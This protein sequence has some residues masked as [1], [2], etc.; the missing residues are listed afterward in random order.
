MFKIVINVF[1]TRHSFKNEGQL[2]PKP[3]F[4]YLLS[5]KWKENTKD[6]QKSE[7][8]REKKKDEKGKLTKLWKLLKYLALSWWYLSEGW[9]DITKKV[10]VTLSQKSGGGLLYLKRY[11]WDMRIEEWSNGRGSYIGR[12]DITFY[13]ALTPRS[14]V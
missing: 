5:S 12:V 14:T 4:Y 8:E 11:F 9:R 6:D 10:R 1:W 3:L 13:W 7:R 2:I